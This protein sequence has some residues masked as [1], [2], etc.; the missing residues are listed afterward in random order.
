MVESELGKVPKS[1]EVKSFTQ[2]LKLG[3]GGTP[4]TNDSEYWN[5]EIPFFTPADVSESY[6]SIKTEKNITE[7]GLKNCS[8]KLYPKDTIFVTARGTVGA[9]SI[10]GCDMSM[11]QSCYAITDVK[12]NSKYFPHQLTVE[13]L[14]RLKNEATGAVFSALVTRDFE[15]Q[16]IIE[17]DEN[18]ILNFDKTAKGIYDLILLFEKENSYLSNLKD[19]LLSKIASIKN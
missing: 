6:Y 5:G 1:W 9:V 16:N 4:N 19:L 18:I 11:N 15:G 2:I 10:A 7:K 13:T 17:P 8:S 14:G 3:G 12:R